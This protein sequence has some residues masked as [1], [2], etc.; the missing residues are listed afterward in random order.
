MPLIAG[1][2]GGVGGLVLIM[3]ACSG[4][5]MYRKKNVVLVQTHVAGDETAVVASGNVVQPYDLLNQSEKSPGTL[6]TIAVGSPGGKSIDTGKSTG[7]DMEDNKV[8]QSMKSTGTYNALGQSD[9][10]TGSLEEHV[11]GSST[12]MDRANV[13]LRPQPVPQ[14]LQPTTA[15]PS[16]FRLPPLSQNP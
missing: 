1:V 5:Y 7:V 16:Q 4:V 10:S 8:G 13:P 15:L 12:E 11:M 14:Y 6:G 9:K 3:L 2:V